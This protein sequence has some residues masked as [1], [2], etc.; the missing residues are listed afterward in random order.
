[1]FEGLLGAGL[2]FAGSMITNAQ[3]I[4]AQEKANSEMMAFQERMSSTAHQREVADLK[5]AGLNPIL[6]ATGGSGAST[7]M[8]TAQI[9]SAQNPIASAIEGY[10]SVI[11]AKNKT[12]QAALT[13]AQKL[14]EA[15]KQAA[16]ISTARQA[17]E[18]ANGIALQNRVLNA[19]ID[20]KINSEKSSNELKSMQN[21]WDRK[22]IDYDNY[23]RRILQGTQTAAAGTQALGN[24]M[25]IIPGGAMKALKGA[26]KGLMQP[27]ESVPTPT[28]Q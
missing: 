14:T 11:D 15:T 18:N 1:M 9:S 17:D 8:G 3:N 2:G 20:S 4:H 23:M 16:N 13:D 7:P 10:N 27:K 6:S 28:Q 21:K 24:L 19:T 12:A 5:A 22:S 25:E 26:A